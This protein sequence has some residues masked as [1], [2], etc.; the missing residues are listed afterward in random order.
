MQ[1]PPTLVVESTVEINPE[2]P[3]LTKYSQKIPK[4]F[5]HDSHYLSSDPAQT[6]GLSHLLPDGVKAGATCQG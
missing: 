4:F 2:K 3:R 5:Q 6:T 1:K